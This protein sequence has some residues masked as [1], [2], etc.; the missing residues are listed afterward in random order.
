MVRADPHHLPVE[1]GN[2]VEEDKIM[3]I[4]EEDKIVTNS[5]TIKAGNMVE[6]LEG[7]ITHADKGKDAIRALNSVQLLGGAGQLVARATDRYRLIEG[8]IE[9]EGH[10]DHSLIALD[11]VKRVI[12]LVKDNKYGSITLTRVGDLLTASINGSAITLQLLG[13]NYPKTFSDLLNKEERD[14]MKV[15]SFNPAYMADYAKIAGKGN[16]IKVEF[17]GEGKPMVIVLKGDKV[18]W[19]A[20]LMPMRIAE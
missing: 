19:K 12:S 3:N 14:S 10:L 2:I 1:E 15:M 4:V 9:G 13:E 17:Q 18:E 7:A 20:L 8:K 16:A 5:L 6:L 11:D